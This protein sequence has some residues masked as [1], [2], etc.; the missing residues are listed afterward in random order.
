MRAIVLSGGANK[1]A[2]HCGVLKHLICDRQ[3]DYNI[4]CGTSVGALNCAFLSMYDN[5][6]PGIEELIN[7]WKNLKED[8]VLKRHFPFGRLHG[9]WKPNLYNSS[10]IKDKINKI[11]DLEKIRKT[12]NLVYVDSVCMDNGKLYS[13]NQTNDEFKKYVL[14]SCSFPGFFEPVKI[15]NKLF[16]DGGIKSVTPLT[17]AIESGANI[18]DVIICSPE[19]NNQAMPD[20]NSITILKRTVDLMIESIIESDIKKALLYN[21]ILEHEN[22]PG[23]RKVK[24][25]IIRPEF[26]LTQ[27]GF[28]FNESKI[29][30]M[31]DYG[32][33][34]AKM[35]YKDV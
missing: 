10:P 34:L 8:D 25:N 28:D 32:Y 21:K 4:L 31:I 2:F 16:L 35:L 14:A 11:I 12:N 9:L 13:I 24:I 26:Q 7:I 1:G 19:N 27:D 23:K 30:Y 22:I 18:I 6:K 20:A 17:N 33:W 29:N 3:I 5:K 15:N